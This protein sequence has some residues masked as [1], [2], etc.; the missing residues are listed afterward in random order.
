MKAARWRL[1]IPVQLTLL[2]GLTAGVQGVTAILLAK[3]LGANDR[4]IL[5]LA[6][7]LVNLLVLA[8][9][10]GVLASARI[11]L[12]S[13]G[14]GL[15][16]RQ[17]VRTTRILLLPDLVVTSVVALTVFPL[18]VRFFDPLLAAGLV[19]MGLAHLR[20]GLLREGLHGVGWHR[21]AVLGEFGGA[22]GSLL[23]LAGLWAGGALTLH[24][25]MLAI[26]ARPLLHHLLQALGVRRVVA[27]EQ[28]GT[29][30]ASGKLGRLIRFSL[31]GLGVAAGMSVA[32]QMD[33]LLLGA[34]A[35]PAPVGVYASAATLSVLAGTLPAAVSPM[36]VREVAQRWEPGL[37]RRW[38]WRVMAASLALSLVIGAIGAAL[39]ELWLG[40]EFAGSTPILAL[41]L[42]G[43]MAM[44][45]QLVDNA[46]N[47]G[48]GDLRASATSA[49]AGVPVGLVSYLVLIPLG[50]MLG[51]A[52][53]NVITYLAMA[54]VARRLMRRRIARA[55]GGPHGG[56]EGT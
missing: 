21:T 16:L 10:L 55:V 43:G 37:H 20:S 6:Q 24:T 41:L 34:F 53:G 7:T 4:G 1:G 15:S 18:L 28:P 47:N 13:P 50:G 2:T 56:G 45:S 27:T 49:L 44:A 31:P 12:S 39:L 42:V 29:A 36:I 30:A 26:V 48:F 25:G 9:S 22:L 35:G 11:V 40:G 32:G 8:L 5:A 38:W 14:W 46:V 3:W 54:I 52:L 17:Y 19:V 51:C 23:L 33:R